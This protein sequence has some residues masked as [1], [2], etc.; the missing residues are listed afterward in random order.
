MTFGRNTL[1]TFRF[2]Q[3]V[4]GRKHMFDH[5]VRSSCHPVPW[6]AYFDQVLYQLRGLSVPPNTH[7]WSPITV[8]FV[9][10]M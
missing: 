4:Q 5:P 7:V 10:S 1:Q 2:S 8:R 9:L 3:L 6:G